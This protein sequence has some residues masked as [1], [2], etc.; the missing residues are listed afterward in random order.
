MIIVVKI[1]IRFI[2][3]LHFKA[4]CKKYCWYVDFYSKEYNHFVSNDYGN[5]NMNAGCGEYNVCFYFHC[6]YV[7]SSAKGLYSNDYSIA[8]INKIDSLSTGRI[9]DKYNSLLER[10]FYISPGTINE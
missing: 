2:G 1:W 9:D 10:Y 6:W 3:F 5:E 8:N 7:D 4:G